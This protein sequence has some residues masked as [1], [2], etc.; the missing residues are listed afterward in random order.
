MALSDRVLMLTNYLPILIFLGVAAGL[1]AL[2]LLLGT[3]IGRYFARFP[4]E[5][6]GRRY[7]AEVVTKYSGAALSLRPFADVVELVDTLA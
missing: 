2:L 5:R 4:G 1:A 3:G 7:A 6:A